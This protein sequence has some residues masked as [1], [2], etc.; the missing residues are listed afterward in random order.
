MNK[1][2]KIELLSQAIAVEIELLI[3]EHYSCEEIAQIGSMMF[4]KS[5]N[6]LLRNF[7]LSKLVQIYKQ[8]L[9]RSNYISIKLYCSYRKMLVEVPILVKDSLKLVKEKNNQGFNM[10]APL[11]FNLALS[12]IVDDE[13]CTFLS[14]KKLCKY[15]KICQ[16]R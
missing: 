3:A 12:M 13:I 14:K 8:N 10:E 4:I 11:S 1:N 16:S 6:K 5:I 7:Y 2:Q 9:F 15:S